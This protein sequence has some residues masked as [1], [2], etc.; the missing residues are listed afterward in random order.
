MVNKM[1]ENCKRSKSFHNLFNESKE[2][3]VK[4]STYYGTIRQAIDKTLDI[5]NRSFTYF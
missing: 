2:A 3:Y 4:N 1:R 5:V